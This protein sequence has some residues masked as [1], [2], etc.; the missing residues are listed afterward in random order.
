MLT[1]HQLAKSFAL[2]TLFENATFSVNVGDRLGLVGPNGCGKSTLLRIIAGVESATAGRVSLVP[3]VRVGYLAQGFELA[4]ELTLRQVVGRAAGDISVL[5]AELATAAAGLAHSPADEGLQRRYDDL[6]R[7]VS[8]ADTGRA[9]SILFGLGLADL[10]PDLP[11]GLLSGG[12]KTRLNLALVLLDDPQLLLLDEPTNHLDIAMLEWLEEWLASFSGGVLLVSHDR[13]F[14]DRTVNRILSMD[15]LSRKVNEYPGNYSD[16]ETQM[17][18]AREKQ[19]AAYHDQQQEIRRVKN[20]IARVKAQ[21]A[22]TERQVSSVSV[23]GRDIKN[24]KDFYARIAKKVASKAKAREHKLQRYLDSEDRVERPRQQWAMKLDFAETTHLGRAVL[25][26][27]GLS[28]GYNPLPPLLRDIR[29]EA[30]PG[31][32][33][34]VSG[35]NGSGKTTLLRTIAGQLAP[36][37]GQVDLGPSVRLGYMSQEQD[38]LDSTLSPVE[39]LRHA[40]ASET[41]VRS[42]LAYFLFT[43]DE[44]L[45]PNSQL[46]YGQRSRLALAQLVASGCNLLLLDEPINHLDIASREQFEQ[47]LGG[48]EGTVLAVIHDRYFI[49]RFA[50]EIWWAEGGCV[51]R[52]YGLNSDNRGGFQ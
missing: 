39:T 5:E 8:S 45:K 33:I 35:P 13:T 23:G 11:V 25:R 50:D 26:L 4:P 37:S 30:T 18:L 19:W 3:G 22:F 16:Y 2:K 17:T 1:V 46:S 44:P 36:L 32:R 38:D 10:S 51:R 28:V 47:A 40:F 14:L 34:V 31:Q 12:Q 43:G 52:L 21:A 15:E 42:F 9:A 27:D 24:S 41:A 7:R 6:L 29:L 49:E 20:D 48:F